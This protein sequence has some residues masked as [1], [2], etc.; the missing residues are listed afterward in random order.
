MSK[1]LNR[2]S[3]VLAGKVLIASVLAGGL[4]VGCSNPST[5]TANTQTKETT[6][7]NGNSDKKIQSHVKGQLLVLQRM[8]LPANAVVEVRLEDVSLMDAPSVTIS[9]TS[10]KT[11]GK[12]SPFAFDLVYDATKIA[13][14]ARI[15]IQAS[16]K[17]DGRLLFVTDTMNEVINNGVTDNIEIILKAVQQ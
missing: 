14:H 12:Q 8:A 7:M 13:S 15:A 17:V 9:E 6:N 10:Y 5:S 11:D 2:P 4:L 1:N 16:I 3:L